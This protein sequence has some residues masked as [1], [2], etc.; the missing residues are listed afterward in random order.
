[1]L[2]ADA[3]TANIKRIPLLVTR[4]TMGITCLKEG[5]DIEK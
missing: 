2:G 1:M 3:M 5:I 4:I